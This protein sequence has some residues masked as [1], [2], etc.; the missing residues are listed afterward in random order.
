MQPTRWLL[1][2]VLLL[3]GI[4]W[5]GQ[6]TGLLEGSSP[7]VGEPFWAFAGAVAVIAGA[8]LAGITLRGRGA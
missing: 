7:M 3:V 2:S 8:V 5:I 4:V 1:I 6:G